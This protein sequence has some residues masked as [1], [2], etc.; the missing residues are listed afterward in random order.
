MSEFDF[1]SLIKPEK[2]SKEVKKETLQDITPKEVS[3]SKKVSIPGPAKTP[4]KT[5]TPSK[6]K[7]ST[8]ETPFDFDEADFAILEIL[9]EKY[10][11]KGVNVVRHNMRNPFIEDLGRLTYYLQQSDSFKQMY[12][13]GLLQKTKYS[14]QWQIK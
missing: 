10:K 11:E 3:P 13:Q 12:K 5:V 4:E 9:A 1:S 7:V 6:T 14:G 2:E 8:V